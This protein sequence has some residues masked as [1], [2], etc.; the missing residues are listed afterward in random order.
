MGYP[1]GN[2]IISKGEMKLERTIWDLYD[3]KILE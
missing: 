2:N 1:K 3:H